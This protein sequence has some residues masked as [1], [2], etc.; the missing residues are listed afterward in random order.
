[1]SAIMMISWGIV[2]TCAAVVIIWLTIATIAILRSM[3]KPVET[4]TEDVK[5]PRETRPD[6]AP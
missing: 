2:I 4:T 3:G 6:Q 1:M 5:T